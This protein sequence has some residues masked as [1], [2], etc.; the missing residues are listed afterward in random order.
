MF[1]YVGRLI[2]VFS[3]G[4]TERF[5]RINLTDRTIKEEAVNPE[6]Q[7]KFLGSRGL[8]AKYYYDEIGKDIKQFLHQ[9]KLIFFRSTNRFAWTGYHQNR[10]NQLVT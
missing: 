2:K 10:I 3:G 7:K 5:V 6:W 1:R 8:A 9:N 4:Y